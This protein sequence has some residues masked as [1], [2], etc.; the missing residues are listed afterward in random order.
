MERFFDNCDV[1]HFIADTF[2]CLLL[3]LNCF[4]LGKLGA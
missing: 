4:G 1:C 3:V 2:L